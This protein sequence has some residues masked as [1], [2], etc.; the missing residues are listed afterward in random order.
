MPAPVAGKSAEFREKGGEVYLAVVEREA[1]EAEE[2]VAA[3]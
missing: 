2:T 1:A 3:D